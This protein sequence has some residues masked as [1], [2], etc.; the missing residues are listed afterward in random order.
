MSDIH[1]DPES[2][3]DDPLPP[4]VSPP[5][6]S[7]PL[8]EAGH[9]HGHPV[10][11][12]LSSPVPPHPSRPPWRWGLAFAG[13][14]VGYLVML[15]AG[16]EL[17]DFA[18]AGLQAIPFAILAALAYA[19]RPEI[20]LSRGVAIGYWVAMTVA[21]CLFV[22]F[23]TIAALV[24][25]GDIAQSFSHR[26]A[27][28]QVAGSFL[29][30]GISG[31]VGLAC[32]MP[33]VRQKAAQILPMDPSS[34]VHAAALA[35]AVSV[36]LIFV[37]PLLIVH[38]PPMLLLIQ[39]DSFSVLKD[40]DSSL[41]GTLY[42]LIWSAPASFVAVGFPFRRLFGEARQRLGLVWP[43]WRQ[44]LAAA[45]MTLVLLVCMHFL[46]IGVE[47]LWR[48][49]GWRLTDAGAI[50]VLFEFGA[51]PLAAVLVGVSA[52]LG[53]ELVFRGVLQPRLGIVLPALMFT[54]VHAL[55]Y[56]FDALIQVLCLGLAFGLIRKW[57]NTTT[58][59][60]IHGGYDC[61]LLLGMYF[62]K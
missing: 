41:R 53:E 30:L 32:F 52:G 13:L 5:A 24:D 49:E 31:V 26:S 27:V 16:G 47:M 19:A 33:T 54:A 1:D 60:I 18:V 44:F 59:A 14:G 29:A 35:T 28:I 22:W 4:A 34:F 7:P 3:A 56:N 8:Y 51:G 48:A 42:G 20:P 17:R 10:P 39:R 6:I 9:P 61:L 12:L 55:Q 50:N 38:D 11:P 45:V 58:C 21:L 46:E 25:P 37:V 40:A 57:S 2:L 23:F 62:S 43:S 15:I 36:T